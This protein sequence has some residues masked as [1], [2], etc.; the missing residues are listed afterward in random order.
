MRGLTFRDMGCRRQNK[1]LQKVMQK[2][3]NI[4][5]KNE[6]AWIYE[7]P[8]TR[9]SMLLNTAMTYALIWY[10]KAEKIL[11]GDDFPAK[12]NLLPSKDL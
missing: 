3:N 1:H 6:G 2:S 5:L 11:K 9:G 7:E 10:F 12:P 4:I 8:K